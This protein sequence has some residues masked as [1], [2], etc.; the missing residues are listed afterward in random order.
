MEDLIMELIDGQEYV[1]IKPFNTV[2]IN[3]VMIDWTP[4]DSRTKWGTPI[5]DRIVDGEIVWRSPKT[6]YTETPLIILNKKPYY[7]R[8]RIMV[9]GTFDDDLLVAGYQKI[10]VWL[11][12]LV[13]YTYMEGMLVPHA[14]PSIKKPKKKKIID[15]DG[16]G[17]LSSD[18]LAL[19]IEAQE[20][21]MLRDVY[22]YLD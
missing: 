1:T 20:V 19:D 12:A 22:D 6:R 9:A 14:V 3:D 4:D 13:F 10:L 2:I 7:Q 15:D 8:R 17:Q 16:Y 5:E 18:E 21:D 11:D